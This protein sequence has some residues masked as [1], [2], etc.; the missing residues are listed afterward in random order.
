MLAAVALRELA[1][2]DSPTQAKRA[3]KRAVEAVA[4]MLG[5][6]PTIC[7]K[8]YIHPAVID[9]YLEGSITP[10]L[11]ARAERRMATGVRGLTP[12]EAAVVGLL[13]QR[14]AREKDRDAARAA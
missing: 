11:K 12:E 4:R 5:N 8:G 14:L 1:A 9:A 3:M 2:F 13:Q 6:T 10:V 7:R